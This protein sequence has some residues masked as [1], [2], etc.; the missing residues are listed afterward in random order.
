MGY[1]H[2]PGCAHLAWLDTTTEPPPRCHH[3]ETALA[4][5]PAP[6]VRSLQERF[7][8]DMRLDAGRP[9]FVRS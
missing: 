1:L 9:R 3:C 2:C 8:R 6:V 4:P 7:E 5:L